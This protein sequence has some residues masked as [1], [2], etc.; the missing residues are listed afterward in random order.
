MPAYFS[1]FPTIRYKSENTDSTAKNIL[2]RGILRDEA[3]KVLLETIEIKS[4]DRA[5]YLSHLLYEN[6][7]YDYL[8]YILNDIVDPYYEWH[9]TKEQLDEYLANKYIDSDG[10]DTIDDVKYWKAITTNNSLAA[11]QIRDPGTGYVNNDVV[12]VGQN[13]N[14]A[15]GTARIIT[16]D[17]GG[18]A[19]FIIVNP[20]SN[21]TKPDSILYRRNNLPLDNTTAIIVP[22]LE[23][24]NGLDLIINT[25]TYDLL[26]NFQQIKYESVT[27]REYEE[28]LNY[29]RRLFN[30]VRPEKASIIQSQMKKLLNGQGK[31]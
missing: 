22:V 25:E 16:D 8:F 9:L 14:N 17:D 2:L 4:G 18:I 26:P 13:K 28:E 29:Q 27:N 10:V 3:K 20:G 11:I 24:F 23:S 7:E 19:N 30:A 6:P 5:D 1:N 12:F 15:L 21:I 31:L